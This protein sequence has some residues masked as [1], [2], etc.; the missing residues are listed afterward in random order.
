MA[1]LYACPSP[2]ICAVRFELWSCWSASA[3]LLKLPQG[4]ARA[5]LLVYALSLS[6]LNSQ[7]Q[8][9]I[10]AASIQA[11]VRLRVNL[12]ADIC[13]SQKIADSKIDPKA[14]AIIYIR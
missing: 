14:S 11:I 7:R 1:E 12:R 6:E 4:D 8:A 3:G 5:G 13:C 2:Q 9:D 10:V